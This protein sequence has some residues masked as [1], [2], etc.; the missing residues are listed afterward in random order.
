MISLLV[1]VFNEED[2]IMFFYDEVRRKLASLDHEVAI[3]F[4]DDGSKDS[5]LAIIKELAAKDP[6]VTYLSFSRNFGKEPAMMA[7]LDYAEGDAVIPIDIDLQDPIEVIPQLLA[8]WHEGAS[9]VLAKRKHRESD[10]FFKRNSAEIFYWLHNKIADF[11]IEANVGDFRL[12]DRKVVDALKTLPERNL[13]M[14]GVFS[15]VGF[16]QAVVEYDRA[17]RKAGKSKF[18]GW[19]LW[20]FA[21][22]GITSFSS[23]P[24]R[25]WTYVGA[26][27]SFFAFAYAAWMILKQWI[28]GNPVP[29]YPSLMVTILFLGG[30]Q[31]IGIGIIGEYL[32]RIY[33]ESKKRPRYILKDGNIPQKSNNP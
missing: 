2:S 30:I 3:L 5:S 19:K 25:I 16:P 28:W 4:V 29:G 13:F 17:P 10:G 23:W 24:L 33:Y 8:K 20:N 11:P 21:L 6:L 26:F 7:G 12:L 14:K 1:P 15:W 18:N 22:E 27:I 31:L 32:G 9:V